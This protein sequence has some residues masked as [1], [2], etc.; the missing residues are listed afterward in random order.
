MNRHQN[1]SSQAVALTEL[2]AALANY[3][4]CL[5]DS[6]AIF[7]GENQYSGLELALSHFETWLGEYL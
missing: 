6:A 4:E 2:K 1:P 7:V 3:R 5:E